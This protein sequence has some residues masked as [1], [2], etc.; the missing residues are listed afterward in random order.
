MGHTVRSAAKWLA[1][2]CASVAVAP[3]LLSYFT[4]ARLLG[5][6]RALASSSQTL[7]LVPGLMGQYI[8][9]AFYARVLERC[10]PSVT[11]EF[12]VLLSKAGARL[13][14]NVYVGPGSK[15]GLVH[16]ER[17]CLIGPD[18]H[19]PSGRTT[20]G[21]DDVDRPIR[22][23]SGTV[24]TIRIGAGSWIGSTAVVMAD[25]GRGTVV[26]AGAIVT[27]AL[28]DHVVAVGVPAAVVKTRRG[29]A[30][31]QPHGRE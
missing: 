10:H 27:R 6:D 1:Y 2:W 4:R 30:A 28:P 8:R 11:L 23:Q 19:I 5:R 24:S 15:L 7:S 29:L 12:G 9:R 25:V 20:H 22:E 13:D 17:D 26:G 31:S 14:E 16:V 21:T 3:S 18:V